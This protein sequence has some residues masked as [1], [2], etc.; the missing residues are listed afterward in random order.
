MTPRPLAAVAGALA[1]MLF[2]GCRDEQA[3]PKGP[4][5]SGKSVSGTVTARAGGKL[6]LEGAILDVPPGALPAGT[7]SLEITLTST[8][9]APVG[10]PSWSSPV[11]RLEPEGFRFAKP[12]TLTLPITG[13]TAAVEILWTRLGNTGVYEDIGGKVTAQRV[14]ALNTHFSLATARQQG[15]TLPTGSKGVSALRDPR[16]AEALC[17]QADGTLCGPGSSCCAGLQCVGGT[18]APG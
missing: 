1:V 15:C 14:A 4:L 2:P 3:E 5:G 10:F 16:A 12:V 8:K 13:G 17:C 6:E 11:F 9:L 7:S 18:C